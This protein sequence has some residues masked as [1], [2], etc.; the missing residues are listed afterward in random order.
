MLK[1]IVS[2]GQ[3]GVD[4]AAL[5]AATAAGYMHGGW[6]PRGRRAEDGSIP[7]HYSLQETPRKEYRQ[8]TEWNVRDSD[9]T[10]VLVRKRIKG[11]TL[12]TLRCLAEAG[13][14]SLV[15]DPDRKERI[16]EVVRWLECFSVEVLNIAGPRASSDPHI[17]RSSLKFLEELF[18]ALRMQPRNP[19]G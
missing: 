16:G 5:D 2:G 3:S 13:R 9:A 18:S 1:K 19:A 4:R 14:P 8:R 12:Y 15:I 17:Y 10:L 6:C 7:G 11:G